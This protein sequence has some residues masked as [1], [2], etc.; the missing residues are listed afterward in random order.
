MLVELEEMKKWRIFS[1]KIRR[2][3]GNLI[4]FLFPLSHIVFAVSSPPSTFGYACRV[5]IERRISLETE[6]GIV[7]VTFAMRS[8]DVD[9]FF[10]L[11]QW[12]AVQSGEQEN[13]V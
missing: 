13:R 6:I 12:E 11:V 10:A 7:F 4:F 5:T 1:L 9:K 3:S 8:C 2:F